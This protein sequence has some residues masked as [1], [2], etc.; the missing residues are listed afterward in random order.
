MNNPFYFCIGLALNFW[1]LAAAI[2]FYE[3]TLELFQSKE[4]DATE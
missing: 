4:D 2:K 1:T 3:L